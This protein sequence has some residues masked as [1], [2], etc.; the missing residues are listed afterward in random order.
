MKASVVTEST[1][2]TCGSKRAGI[3]ATPPPR[4]VEA[5]DRFPPIADSRFANLKTFGKFSWPWFVNGLH[6]PQDMPKSNP[7]SRRIGY[8]RVTTYGRTLDA[9]LDQL[10]KG[11]FQ[12][13]GICGGGNVPCHSEATF[14][15]PD[16]YFRWRFSLPTRDKS[17][18][19]R[20][21]LGRAQ[22]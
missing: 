7:Q 4:W 13:G 1:P 22:T 14:K 3:A 20:K 9:Q 15:I 16:R 11:V 6:F 18:R 5:K 17:A 12:T 19:P 21:S 2:A 8:A 10:R